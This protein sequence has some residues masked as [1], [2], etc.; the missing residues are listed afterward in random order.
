VCGQGRGQFLC[1]SVILPDF[2]ST[3]MRRYNTNIEYRPYTVH[4]TSIVGVCQTPE[5]SAVSYAADAR[6]YA[7]LNE[8]LAA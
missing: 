3:S 8:Y 5:C 7:V 4:F 2:S 6:F 1:D